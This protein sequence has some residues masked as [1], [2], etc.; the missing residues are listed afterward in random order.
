MSIS[1]VAGNLAWIGIGVQEEGGVEIVGPFG[2]GRSLASL[3]FGG[4][5]ERL[6]V[7]LGEGLLEQL[8]SAFEKEVRGAMREALR[9]GILA[10][11]PDAAIV[12]GALQR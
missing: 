8:R 9:L 3:D 6:S 1:E 5:S 2:S 4:G 12:R 11:K 7:W 10:L